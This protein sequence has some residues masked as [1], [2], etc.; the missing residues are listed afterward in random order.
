MF[1]NEEATT[2]YDIKE[3]KT[4]INYANKKLQMLTEYLCGQIVNKIDE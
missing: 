2:S 3:R 4:F 1:L